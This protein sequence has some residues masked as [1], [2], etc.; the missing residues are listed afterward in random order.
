MA[1]E[2]LVF[3]E[4]TKVR[5]LTETELFVDGVFQRI[6]AQRRI[7]VE[8]RDSQSCRPDARARACLFVSDSRL[9]HEAFLFVPERLQVKV[10]SN[11]PPNKSTG[12]TTSLSGVK[13]R[14]GR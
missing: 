1:S 6:A 9:G 7:K 5:G 11:F 4:E 8:D 2:K 14:T 3:E 13:G 10:K 12:T